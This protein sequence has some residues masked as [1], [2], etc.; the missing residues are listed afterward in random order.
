MAS[1]KP[2]LTISIAIAGL[3]VIAS[4][5]TFYFVIWPWIEPPPASASA[6]EGRWRV[7]EGWAAYDRSCKVDPIAV[8]VIA[9]GTRSQDA[10]EALFAKKTGYPRLARA[11]LPAETQAA[12]RALE[13]W[14]GKGGGFAIPLGSDPSY[15]FGLLELGKVALATAP[16]LDDPAVS[17]ALY[18]A[19]TLRRCGNY[20]AAVTGFGLSEAILR[21]LDDRGLKPDARFA[22]FRPTRDELF[23]AVARGAVSAYEDSRGAGYVM[24]E[25]PIYA[26]FFFDADRELAWLKYAGAERLFAANASGRDPARTAALFPSDANALP[27][28]GLVRLHFMFVGIVIGKLGKVI[29]RYDAALAAH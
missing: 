11:E 17:S 26:R 1:P 15:Y 23:V 18:T 8:S 9:A 21:W 14:S 4:A 2:I 16:A 24:L 6:I 10:H 7:A 5:I 25:V 12:L 22:E 28:S 29:E 20:S 3:V 13:E 19:K 27:K